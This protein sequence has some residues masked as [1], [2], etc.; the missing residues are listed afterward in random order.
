MSA[1]NPTPIEQIAALA[2]RMRPHWSKT[3]VEHLEAE[4]ET[5]AI[6]PEPDLVRAGALVV[7][8]MERK[9]A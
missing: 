2:D 1:P 7:I 5:A 4:L 3:A 9:A 6:G 8:M